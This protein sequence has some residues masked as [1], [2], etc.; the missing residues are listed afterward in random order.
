MVYH[1]KTQGADCQP[2]PGNVLTVNCRI[3]NQ[4]KQSEEKYGA[5][6]NRN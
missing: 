5:M 3:A 4:V 1:F 6:R 2:F